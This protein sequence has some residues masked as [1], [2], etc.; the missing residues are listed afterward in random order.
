[1]I[2]KDLSGP[3]GLIVKFSTLQEYGVDRVFFLENKN[4]DSLQK[5]I[6][7]IVHGEN[8][9]QIQLTAGERQDQRSAIATLVTNC[10]TLA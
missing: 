2:S 6:V 1:M 4:V 9:T 7:F 5:N 8:A 3:L 10:F